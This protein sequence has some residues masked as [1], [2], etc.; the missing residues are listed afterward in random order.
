MSCNLENVALRVYNSANVTENYPKWYQF[1]I[2]SISTR[3]PAVRVPE[4][5]VFVFATFEW[6]STLIINLTFSVKVSYYY[7]YSLVSKFCTL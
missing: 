5:Y 3:V 2:Q 1:V 7:Y 6:V 4:Y